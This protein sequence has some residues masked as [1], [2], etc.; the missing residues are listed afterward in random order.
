[1]IAWGHKITEFGENEAEKLIGKDI[2][3]CQIAERGAM[4]YHGGV[5]EARPV[6]TVQTECEEQ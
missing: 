1:M 3:A 5:F 4:G 6:C 2:V